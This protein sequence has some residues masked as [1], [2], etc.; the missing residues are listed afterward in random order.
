MAVVVQVQALASG[1]SHESLLRVSFA[2]RLLSGVINRIAHHAAKVGR[3]LT[4]RRCN[5]LL[6][7]LLIALLLLSGEALPFGFLIGALLCLALDFSNRFLAFTIFRVP[8]IVNRARIAAGDLAL[9]S[10][11]QF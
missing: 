8:H 3:C 10:D 9:L 1:P 4:A 2:V 11:A 6:V 7:K 5:H